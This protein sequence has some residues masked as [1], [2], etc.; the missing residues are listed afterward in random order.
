MATQRG[1]QASPSLAW[2]LMRA[3]EILYSE[4]IGDEVKALGIDVVAVEPGAFPTY[5]FNNALYANDASRSN[6]YGAVA[7]I[8][9]KMGEGLGQLIGSS[10]VSPQGR[11]RRDSQS[12][13]DAGGTRP[14]RVMVGNLSGGPVTAMNEEYLRPRHGILAAFGL[15]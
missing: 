14:M 3:V 13:Q 5:V 4:A 15:A 2:A 6:G 11:G 1:P 9:Q 7:Q 8:P 12:G 10:Q